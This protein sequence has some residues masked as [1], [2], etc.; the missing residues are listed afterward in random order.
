VGE[1]K[2]RKKGEREGARERGSEGGSEGPSQQALEGVQAHL[3][4]GGRGERE[5]HQRDPWGRGEGG[6]RHIRE[7][8]GENLQRSAQTH[9]RRGR[10]ITIF[11][12]Q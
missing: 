12:R 6:E 9:N 11:E 5:T 8:H 1:G 10:R 2:G 7:T 3:W 4:V